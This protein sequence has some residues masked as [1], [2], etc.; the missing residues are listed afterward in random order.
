MQVFIFPAGQ[1]REKNLERSGVFYG[2]DSARNA[3][4][5]APSHP[6]PTPEHAR[7]S[8]S[9]VRRSGVG[10]AVAGRISGTSVRTAIRSAVSVAVW[11]AVRAA[12]RSIGRCAV[13]F[14]V[15]VAVVDC[16]RDSLA[17]ITVVVE[18]ITAIAVVDVDV[19]G[20]I[21]IGPPIRGRSADEVKPE[22]TILEA[23]ITPVEDGPADSEE[24]IAAEAAVKAVLRNYVAA[25]STETVCA[26]VVAGTV[27]AAVSV[28]S[29][30]ARVGT[31]R[32][33][34]PVTRLRELPVLVL[35]PRALL[36]LRKARFRNE[37][38][39]CQLRCSDGA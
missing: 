10:R 14:T 28:A 19:V 36:I 18:I 35:R 6:R 9:T 1:L 2:L 7:D 26:R 4:S 31:I 20:V 38:L 13:A 17:G 22:S 24:V 23:R 34:L 29:I 30:L 15:G 21:P 11:A 12:V 25:G 16:K 27:V 32:R 8:D 37:S 3:P 39:R 33:L 5:G